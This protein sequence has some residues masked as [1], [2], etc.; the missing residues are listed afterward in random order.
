MMDAEH[1]AHL[2]R[3][4]DEFAHEARA[5]YEAGQRDHGGN[6]WENPAVLDEAI[7]EAIDQVFYLYS[8]REQRRG[9][10]WPIQQPES[11]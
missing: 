7:K 8:L 3:V 9:C 4:L 6:L 10:R 5:K 1:E 11:D 2:R